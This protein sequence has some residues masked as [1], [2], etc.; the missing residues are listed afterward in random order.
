MSIGEIFFNI[1]KPLRKEN[2]KRLT[3]ETFGELR[4]QVT[5]EELLTRLEELEIDKDKIYINRDSMSPFWYIDGFVCVKILLLTQDLYDEVLGLANTKQRINLIEKTVNDFIK[6]EQYKELFTFTDKPF[7]FPLFEEYYDT[8]PEEQRYEILRDIYI[9]S[10]YGFSEIKKSIIEDLFEKNKSNKF[11][12]KLETDQ[13]GYVKIYRGVGSKSSD[14]ES[15]YSWTLS[16][17]IA[18]FFAN[19]FADSQ[20]TVY[21]AKVHINNIVDYITIRD[22]E[23]ILVLPK[24]I[25]EVIDMGMYNL[26]NSFMNYQDDTL[27]LYNYYKTK[28]KP[29]WFKN[30]EGIHGVLHTKRVLLLSLILSDLEKLSVHDASILVYCSLFHDI[31][32]THDYEDAEH[33]IKSLKKINKAKKDIV[34]LSKDNLNIANFIIENHAIDDVRG[35]SNLQANTKITDKERALKVYS[36]FKDADGLDRLRLGDLDI[37]Y[38]RTESAK[39]LPLVASQLLKQL[40]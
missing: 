30:A 13:E 7:L 10:E 24:D 29:S 14:L 33:G 28:I 22:E 25:E 6:N 34:G 39:K 2:M 16:L 15:A 36:I 8:I 37:S 3:K 17:S 40:K 35:I 23:E 20:S 11:R 38:L 26:S 32:R 19:R 18:L 27:I 21:Q 12:P 1:Q 4:S 5:Y 31:G 9:R